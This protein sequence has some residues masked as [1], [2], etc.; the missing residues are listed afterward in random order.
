MHALWLRTAKVPDPN[1]G[2][3]AGI[4]ELVAYVRKALSG[5]IAA[6]PCLLLAQHSDSFALDTKLFAW[7]LC[8]PQGSE[9]Q[10]ACLARK[11]DCRK[12]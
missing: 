7:G 12:S 4:S 9:Q 5:P 2:L 11:S 6:F 3:G 8:M 1:N 10:R